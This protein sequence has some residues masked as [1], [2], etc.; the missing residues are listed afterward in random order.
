M[1]QLTG[2][3]H[4]ACGEYCCVLRPT[5]AALVSIEQTLDDDIAGLLAKWQQRGIFASEAIVVTMACADCSLPFHRKVLSD[6]LKK[7]IPVFVCHALG[8]VEANLLAEERIYQWDKM[9]AIAVLSFGIAPQDFWAMTVVEYRMLA[10]FSLHNDGGIT[11]QQVTEMV[12]MMRE[13]CGGNDGI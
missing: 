13:N 4:I 12:N 8:I 3:V 2:E 11:A 6:A 5:M 10:E 9:F 7:I 1:N